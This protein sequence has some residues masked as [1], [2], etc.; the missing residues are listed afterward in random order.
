MF[1]LFWQ[2]SHVQLCTQRCLAKE[3]GE[4]EILVLPLNSC[5]TML[6]GADCS[7]SRKEAPL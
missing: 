1:D 4:F 7:S 3:A 2:G 5:Q 6:P